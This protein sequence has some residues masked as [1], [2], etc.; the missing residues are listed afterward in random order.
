MTDIL[1]RSNELTGGYLMTQAT[2]AAVY[3]D[4]DLS[5]TIH[6]HL[7]S[8]VLV[9]YLLHHLYLSVVVTRT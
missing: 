3:H 6:S 4:A 2:A 7:R 8:G 1:Y 5:L 9:K